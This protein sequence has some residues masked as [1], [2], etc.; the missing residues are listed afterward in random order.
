MNQASDVEKLLAPLRELHFEAPRGNERW[1]GHYPKQL[2][3]L[4]KHNGGPLALQPRTSYTTYVAL[5]S[6]EPRRPIL[7]V[8]VLPAM[9]KDYW[10]ITADVST[11]MRGARHDQVLTYSAVVHSKDV[12]DAVQLWRVP[13]DPTYDRL[14]WI[15]ALVYPKWLVPAASN[16]FYKPGTYTRFYVTE[17]DHYLVVGEG[18][19][20]SQSGASR[21]VFPVGD[22]VGLRVQRCSTLC[23]QLVKDVEQKLDKVGSSNGAQVRNSNGRVWAV[24]KK[25]AKLVARMSAAHYKAAILKPKRDILKEVGL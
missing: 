13:K 4:Y 10:W 11:V 20:F 24:T 19:A 6:E 16:M 1:F 22:S 21:R 3:D 12:L 14:G 2:F 25:V 9:V 15:N 8:A 23:R 17:G 18:S 7:R 5:A